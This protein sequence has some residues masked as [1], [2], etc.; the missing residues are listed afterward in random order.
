MPPVIA[1]T[2][3]RVLADYLESVRR[4]G[5]E[6]RILDLSADPQD[7][8]RT[9]DGVLLTGGADIAPERYGE[10][11][12]DRVTHVSEERDAFEIV[13]VRFAREVDLPLLGLCRG[14]QVMNVAFGGTLVQDIPSQVPTATEHQVDDPLAQA[15]ELWIEPQSQLGRIAS[16]G[17]VEATATEISLVVNSRHHQAVKRVAEGFI[18]SATAPD[19]IVEAI[20]LPTARF[21]VGV[22]WHPE[23][24]WRTGEFR[25]LFEAFVNTCEQ[26]GR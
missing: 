4:V 6:P 15:H 22:Q 5:A 24:L 8:V 12:H 25:P 3:C 1:V 17:G 20:E 23:N 11:R 21:H 18:I 14:I 9:V 13:L 19:G 2:H 16:E 7:V 10:P 26:R